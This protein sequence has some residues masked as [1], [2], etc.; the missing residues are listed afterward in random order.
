MKKTL[1]LLLLFA[2]NIFACGGHYFEPYYEHRIYLNFLDNKVLGE[3]KDN[4][5]YYTSYAREV[6][7]NDRKRYYD[8]IEVDLNTKQW[9]DY[10]G[11]S[12]N[13]A[14][15]IIY[16]DKAPI[17]IK[18]KSKQDEFIKYK[19]ITKILN[20]WQ[21][22]DWEKYLSDSLSYFESAKSDFYKLRYAYHIVRSYHHLKEYQKEIDFINS[23]DRNLQSKSIVWEWIDSFKAGAYQN[24]RSNV[25]SAYLF[26]KVF[27]T[28]KT[29][30]YIGYYDFKIKSDMQWQELLK[31]AKNSEEKILFHFLRALNSKNN[32]LYELKE[33]TKIDKNSIWVKRLK[34]MVANHVQYL[35][36][37]NYEDN[38]KSVSLYVD[39]FMAYLKSQDDSF[40]KNIAKYFRYLQTKECQKSDDKKWSEIFDFL[41]YVSNLKTLDEKG[42]EKAVL[43]IEN[44]FKNK[45]IKRSAMQV[46]MD[47]LKELYPK[48]SLK[49]YMAENYD[50][51]L[52]YYDN[53]SFRISMNLDGL[54]EY[55]KFTNK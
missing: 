11:I 19:K 3:E 17:L 23:L 45:E 35:I 54:R 36:Q 52:M 34:F 22:G 33:I 4:P 8:T 21:K 7:Y 28:H 40:S 18:E 53:T 38:K 41:C 16:E 20:K 2:L 46:A 47:K 15:G 12:K 29:D 27:S 39:D 37:D 48:N 55:K 44:S 14:Y 42:L 32:M 30:A 43:K 5:L 51:T 6:T 9:S 50:D 26:S 31:M 25:T 1:L 49:R 24:L 10:L 13:D